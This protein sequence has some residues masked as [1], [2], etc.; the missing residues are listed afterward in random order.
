VSRLHGDES[1]FTLVELLVTMAIAVA[2]FGAVLASLHTMLRQSTVS[3]QASEAQDLARTSVDQIA[4]ALRNAMAAPGIAPTAVERNAANDL[5]FQ[6]VDPSAPVNDNRL[7]AM[8]LRYCLDSADPLRGAL[9]RQTQRWTTATAP[10]MPAATTCDAS[11]NGWDDN[12]VVVRHL[13]NT[14]RSQAVWT[15][16][17]TGYGAAANIRAIETSLI[18]DLDPADVRGERKLTG[19][20]SLRNANRPPVAAF[21]LSQSGGYVIA[22]G[23]A[24]TDPDG[25]NLEYQ[26]WL[27]GSPVAGATGAKWQSGFPAN[28]TQTIELVVTDPSGLTGRSTPPRQVIVQ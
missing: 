15:Y 19:G 4:V 14:A 10:A 25:D 8:R 28:S 7:G 1:G 21:T 27:N 16:G 22:N 24:S 13:V 3:R 23:S 26:W 20:V 11:P 6:S 17:P 18:V 2:A 12:R 5:V 9:R